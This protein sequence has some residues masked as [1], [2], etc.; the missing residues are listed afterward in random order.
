M[1]KMSDGNR[2]VC[3]CVHIGWADSSVQSCCGRVLRRRPLGKKAK[4]LAHRSGSPFM[5]EGKYKKG[6]QISF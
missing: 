5:R 4:V 3:A 1:S 2:R 6:P